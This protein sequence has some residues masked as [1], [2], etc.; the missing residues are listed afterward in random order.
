M[1]NIPAN[2]AYGKRRIRMVVI[3]GIP[4]FSAC[5]ICNIL[6]Y[7]NASKVIGKYCESLP[8]YIKMETAGGPQTLRILTPNDVR[9]ILK[10][11]RRPMAKKFKE[12]FETKVIPAFNAQPN[13]VML[14]EIAAK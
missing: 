10:H 5:D 4:K 13:V 6:G 14:L 7:Y 12:W 9:D 3:N 2:I 1:T 8:E 11:S